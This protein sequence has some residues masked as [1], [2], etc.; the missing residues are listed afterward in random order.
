M[1]YT[2]LFCTLGATAGQLEA[3]CVLMGLN[4][5]LQ[6]SRSHGGRSWSTEAG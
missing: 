4:L 5:L 6:P 3:Q 2:G 1:V